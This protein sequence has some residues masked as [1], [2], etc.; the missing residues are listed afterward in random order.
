MMPGLPENWL[1]NGVILMADRILIIPRRSYF[2]SMT[3]HIFQCQTGSLITNKT[4]PILHS[5]VETLISFDK[6]GKKISPFA[7]RDSVRGFT[8]PGR[9]TLCVVLLPWLK[10]SVAPAVHRGTVGSL[11]P[12]FGTHP[13]SDGDDRC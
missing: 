10:P 2:I 1:Q 11:P 13:L 6:L 8:D 12:R 3:R 7:G 9:A 5:C 4:L